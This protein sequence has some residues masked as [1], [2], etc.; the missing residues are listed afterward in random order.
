MAIAAGPDRPELSASKAVLDM[1]LC[2]LEDERCG[3]EV[4]R[5]AV[6]LNCSAADSD[7]HLITLQSRVLPRLEFVIQDV[8]PFAQP[9]EMARR[10]RPHDAPEGVYSLVS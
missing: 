6:R 8:G 4:E 2:F 10:Q 9:T 7:L 5:R 1:A 3:F